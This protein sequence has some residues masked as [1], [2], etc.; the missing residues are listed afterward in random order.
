LRRGCLFDSRKDAA[1]IVKHG[2]S[3]AKAKEFDWKN[4]YYETDDRRDYGE[5]RVIATGLLSGRIHVMIFTQRMSVYRIISLRK[6][7]ARERKK[8]EKEI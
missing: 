5:H 2:V 7:N 6:A 1:N 4:A 3:L 8:Y